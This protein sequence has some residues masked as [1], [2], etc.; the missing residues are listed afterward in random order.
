MVIF[1]GG[2][3][4]VRGQMSCVRTG[5][6]WIIHTHV[7]WAGGRRSVFAVINRQPCSVMGLEAD[8][9]RRRRFNGTSHPLCGVVL[10]YAGTADARTVALGLNIVK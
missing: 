6:C 10:F 2:R 3:W 4:W 5:L 9:R 7:Q 8:R 1:G